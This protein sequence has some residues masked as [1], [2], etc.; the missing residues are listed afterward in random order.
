MAMA[1][2]L[3]A[4][5]KDGRHNGCMQWLRLRRAEQAKAASA[6]L[7]EETGSG[8]AGGFFSDLRNLHEGF[9]DLLSGSV[10]HG[11]VQ[12]NVCSLVSIFSLTDGM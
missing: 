12:F 3:L 6:Y 9:F 8:V 2:N 11:S 5:Q 4:F 7:F 10:A 1:S